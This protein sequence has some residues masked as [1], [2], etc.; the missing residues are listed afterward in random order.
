MREDSG[1]AELRNCAIV[2]L[3]SRPRNAILLV[4]RDKSGGAERRFYKNLIAKAERWFDR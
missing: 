2:Q 1:G 3:I 4:A